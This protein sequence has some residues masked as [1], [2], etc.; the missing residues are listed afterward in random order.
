MQQVTDGSWK[1][2]LGY[3]H[4]ICWERLPHIQHLEL[5]DVVR[6]RYFIAYDVRDPQR[7]LQVHKIMKGYGD[8][9]QYSVFVCKLNGSEIIM[10]KQD[11]GE[12]M[13]FSEDRLLIINTGAVE[14]DTHNVEVIGMSLEK[15]MEGAIIV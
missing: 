12:A 13:N 1:L 3:S 15:Q 9:V 6:N 11:I 10:L 5:G 4:D 2:K 8:P 14:K 7:L